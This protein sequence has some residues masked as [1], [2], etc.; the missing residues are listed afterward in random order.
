L[1]IFHPFCRTHSSGDHGDQE[2]WAFGK[3][4]TDI[5]R[6]FI[7]I[8]YQLLP[9]LYTA[10]WRYVDEGIPIL[11]SLVLFD[12]KDQHTHYRNDEF[13]FGEKI[14]ACPIAEP[15]A[16][17]RRMY[18]PMG[19]W[20]NFWT[21]ELIEGGEEAWVDADLDSMPIFVKA[22]AVIPKYPIQQYVGEKEIEELVL[23]VY[24]K[25]G[26]ETSQVYE[27]AHDG[28]DYKKGRFSLRNFKLI[29]KKKSLT[30][31]QFKSG[32]YTTSYETF[33]IKLKGLPFKIDKV[34]V[35]NEI[36]DFEKIKINGDNSFVVSKEFTKLIITGK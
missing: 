21:D 30:I 16:K 15:N 17:G 34:E 23:D 24:Y 5:V 6:K 9:Y 3:N 32:K 13:I 10:F 27:D 25:N 1:G 29:G 20:Y 7:E 36:S 33:K 12:Q 11:K 28:Y 18:F 2:P 8:R 26:K 31:Q 22:G 19:E 14:L 4:I 35:D